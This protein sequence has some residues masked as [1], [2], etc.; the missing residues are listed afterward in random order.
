MV[1]LVLAG[2]LAFSLIIFAYSLVARPIGESIVT[3]P[4]VFVTIGL[5]LGSSG[6]DILPL[7]S[8]SSLILI[9]AEIALVLIL[10]SDAARIDRRALMGDRNLPLRLLAIGLPLTI[11]AG[12]A[13]AILL[14]TALTLAEAAL[15]GSILAPPMRA[16][17]RPL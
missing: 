1:P 2:I 8:Q 13:G 3:A 16:W 9:I 4:M 7:R 5:V 12:A 15:I 14:F 11:L 10:F 6:L 17:G